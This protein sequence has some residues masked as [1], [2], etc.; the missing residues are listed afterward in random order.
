[1]KASIKQL[2]EKPEEIINSTEKI[3]QDGIPV[4]K[5]YEVIQEIILYKRMTLITIMGILS[6][7]AIGVL[8][9]A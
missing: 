2:K 3:I 7:L 8:Y 1:M 4:L 9:L 5:L 6:I